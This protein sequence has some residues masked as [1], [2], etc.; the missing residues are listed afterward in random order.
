MASELPNKQSAG[1]MR[2]PA[3]VRSVFRRIAPRYDLAN[4]LLSAG[5]DFWW[6]HRA[7][8]IVGKWKPQRVLDVATGSGDLALAIARRLPEAEVIGADFCPEMLEMARQKGLANRVV[9]DA[10]HLPFQ[11]R[12][13]DV[14]TVAFGLRNMSSW[15]AALAEMARVCKSGGHVLVLDFS[16]PRSPLRTAYRFYLHHCLPWVASVVTGQKDAYQYL[17]DSIE[18]FPSGAEML[19]LIEGSGFTKADALLM[20]GGI[21]SL[22]LAQK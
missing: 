18:K 8:G 1:S 20:T 21:A 2:D 10:L 6:R 15:H 7:A 13:F 3:M 12:S 19:R 5:F 9:A 4:H 14:V 11:D 16:L 17:G 22:Y